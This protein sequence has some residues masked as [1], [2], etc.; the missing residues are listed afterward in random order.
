MKRYTSSIIAI[1]LA[2]SHVVFAQ[3]TSGADGTLRVKVADRGTETEVVKQ[4]TTYVEASSI[5][6][7]RAERLR[8][9]RQDIEVQTEQKIVEKLEQSRLEDEQ[10]RVD[11][12]F[13]GAAAAPVVAPAPTTTIQAPIQQVVVPA[14]TA[15]VVTQDDLNNTKKEILTAIEVQKTEEKPIVEAAK[16]VAAVEIAKDVFQKRYYIGSNV[17]LQDYV[18]VANIDSRG[19]AGILVGSEVDRS[20]LV[21][22]GFLYSNYYIQDLYWGSGVPLFR[23]MN[24]W[25][26]SFAAKYQF[27]INHTFRP[28]VGAMTSYT[29]RKYFDRAIITPGGPQPLPPDQEATSWAFDLGL[30]TGINLL[31]GDNFEIGA[32]FRYSTNLF[33]RSDSDII[34]ANYLPQGA[35]LVEETDYT[36]FLING[37]YRF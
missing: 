31:L 2:F 20:F 35:Q 27:I 22:G 23:E 18:D 4:P 21:E 30:T 25:N 24:Q 15:K 37:F 26:F 1:S 12:I 33:H 28:Y 17:G 14:E 29:Y 8:K 16:T 36:T 34:S 11:K 6:E 7:S 19:A 32:E 10:K 13:G 3:D 5:E 9:A